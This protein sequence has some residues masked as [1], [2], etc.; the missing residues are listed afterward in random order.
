MRVEMYKYFKFFF[1]VLFIACIITFALGLLIDRNNSDIASVGVTILILIAS[2]Y[3]EYYIRTNYENNSD[4][5]I[6]ILYP[7]I[8]SIIYR[9]KAIFIL[10]TIMI[11]FLVNIF[12][13]V[14]T[15]LYIIYTVCYISIVVY[16]HEYGFTFPFSSKRAPRSYKYGNLN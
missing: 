10:I 16:L 7:S 12:F 1:N 14:E 6:Q 5:Y 8:S 9:F 4:D 11:L 3:H 2:R 13:T 15:L